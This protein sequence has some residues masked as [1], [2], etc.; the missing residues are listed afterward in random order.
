[1]KMISY[2]SELIIINYE[3]WKLKAIF[4]IELRIYKTFIT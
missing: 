2:F 4:E 3:F 1:M